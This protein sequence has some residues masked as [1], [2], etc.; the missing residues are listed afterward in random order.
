MSQSDWKKMF[1]QLKAKPSKLQKY[2]KHNAPKDR[3]CGLARIACRRCGK[4]RGH[5]NKYGLDLCRHCFRQ[6]ATQIGFKKYS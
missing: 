3:T 5:I 6:L 4:H 1:K 2:K